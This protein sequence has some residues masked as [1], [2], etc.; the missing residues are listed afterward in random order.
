MSNEKRRLILF[1]ILVF[2]WMI[3]V[4]Y[5]TQFFGPNPPK[6]APAP[7]AAA[8]ADDAARK[9]ADG[10]AAP[11][12]LAKEKSQGA[13]TAPSTDKPG[14]IKAAGDQ[15]KPAGPDAKPAA[16][17]AEPTV[18]IEPEDELVLGSETDTSPNGYRLRAQ[19][20]QIGAGVE[21][22]TS[23]RYDAEY[24][25]GRAI[26]RPLRLINRDVSW[27]N[28]FT[29]TLNAADIDAPIP[30]GA[31]ELALAARQTEDWLDR[32]T[33]EVVRDEQ[34][35][36]RRPATITNPATGKP[37]EGEAIV[38]RTKARNGVVVTK[39]YRMGKDIDGLEV[40]LK[41]DSPDKG[42][43]IVYNLRGPHGIPIEGEWYTS[44]FIDLYFGQLWQD[45]IK[46]ETYTAQ[47]VAKASPDRP[48]DNSAMPLAYAGIENQY[49]ATFLSPVP[50][51]RGQED[52]W[53]NRTVA[54]AH[55]REDAMHKSDVDFVMTSKPVSVA[56]GHPVVHTYRIF[57]GPKTLEALRPYNAE[58]LAT[59][60]KGQWIPGV[61]QIAR[62]VITPTLD[63]MYR[64][65][66]RVSRMFGGKE[67]N[68]GIAIILLTVLV[69]AGMF[70]LG[71][72]QALAAQK[73]QLL[74]P[75]LKEIQEK[76]KEDKERLTKET[77]ALY[78]RYGVNP[79]G[80]CLPALIQLPIFVG[81]WQAINTHTPLR[82]ATFLWIRDLAAPDMLFRFPGEVPWLGHW[83]NLLPLLVVSLMLVQTQLF[84]PP[85]TTPEAEQ[86]QKVMKVMMVVMGV[87]FYKVPSGLG[88]YFITSSMWAIGERLLLPKVTHTDLTEVNE[89]AAEDGRPSGPSGGPDG[90]G[91]GPRGGGKGPSGGNGSSGKRQGRFAQF[92]ERV[93]EEA[94]KD[95]TYR[96]LE[97]EREARKRGRDKGDPR[98][99]P[100]R[101]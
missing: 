3:S 30:P 61:P 51:P 12:E 63:M 99:R 33:W 47:D 44:T 64:L 41:F 16:K 18:K 2:L 22:L 19:F 29:L 56:P 90:E 84:A 20:S 32:E 80:G 35:R 68:Y 11:A 91:R 66:E 77:F 92:V 78:K 6:K 31:D 73:M 21:R 60:R 88:I 70:P 26:K 59:L 25:D 81:L 69:R 24:K 4:Q 86:S 94:Q 5:I 8:G 39:T 36:I 55:R 83:F 40:E 23:S 15:G 1:A 14:E 54:E 49:F 98:G 38:F 7:P 34:E 45:R 96:K 10:K 65:T 85:A 74:Q 46:A 43:K 93:L 87:M 28:S 27:P 37:V 67:G 76:H 9:S 52:R 97:E 48:V 57:A 58:D 100:R 62:Y 82:H 71:R 53:D 101:R 17:P 72:K 42:R 95:S 50:M 13:A 75:M 89:E 79:M